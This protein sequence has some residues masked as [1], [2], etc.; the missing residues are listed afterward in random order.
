MKNIGLIGIIFFLSAFTLFSQ[1]KIK[2][3]VEIEPKKVS[4][5]LKSST[6]H[7]VRLELQW[8]RPDLVLGITIIELPNGTLIGGEEK[9]GGSNSLIVNSIT[10]PGLL[11]IVI[12]TEGSSYFQ[13]GDF[14]TCTF[15][16][17]FDEELKINSSRIIYW[18]AG[19]EIGYRLPLLGRPRMNITE[20]ALC[21]GD[22]SK[23]EFEG[24]INSTDVWRT[25][26]DLI[27]LYFL[28]GSEYV[29]FYDSNKSIGK[30]ISLLY[31]DLLNLLK[32]ASIKYD[33]ICNEGS[34]RIILTA[35]INDIAKYDS[36]NV[37]GKGKYHFESYNGDSPRLFQK[38][39]N[40]TFC[41]GVD[42]E[43]ACPAQDSITDETRFTASLIKGTEI[44][45][46]QDPYTEVEG[47]ELNNLKYIYPTIQVSFKIINDVPEDFDSLII[48][49]TSSDIDIEPYDLIIKKELPKLKVTIVP[50]ELAPG[51]TANVILQKRNADGSYGAFPDG[52]LFYPDLIEGLDYAKLLWEGAQETSFYEIPDGFK[53][54]A[55]D[56]ID[57]DSVKVV[58]RVGTYINDEMPAAA[59]RRSKNNLVIDNKTQTIN[60]DVLPVNEKDKIKKKNDDK[61][62]LLMIGGGGEGEY[63]EGYSNALI[64]EVECCTIDYDDGNPRK[65]PGLTEVTDAMFDITQINNNPKC[66]ETTGSGDNPKDRA[67][68]TYSNI[69]YQNPKYPLCAAYY[70]TNLNFEIIW[71]ICLDHLKD[72]FSDDLIFV[73]QNTNMPQN[74]DDADDMVEDFNRFSFNEAKLHEEVRGEI[75]Y[76]PLPSTTEHE[77]THTEQRKSLME[78]EYNQLLKKIYDN[79]IPP[80]DWCLTENIEK[81]LADRKNKFLNLINATKVQLEKDISDNKIE[82][83]REAYHAGMV[84]R[85]KLIA[86][87]Y[88]SLL[89]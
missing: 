58:L 75:K 70:L 22:T 45:I 72:K 28:E 59:K 21:F 38:G 34:K 66:D 4:K 42:I 17:Y 39:N 36:I 27:K 6:T 48:R 64:T 69:S 8:T 41:M 80:P 55:A 53:L 52:Q 50:S 31:Y 57:V 2:E 10:S 88:H 3:K 15:Q 76:Y 77:L 7:T 83:E 61:P 47:V 89:P 1:V 73:D 68:V 46:L 26:K 67:G 63:V 78:Q 14:Y 44:G 11:D 33:N 56:S 20:T 29:S 35:E 32:H 13:P 74:E 54:V 24:Y 37:N 82:N 60:K 71:G 30:S 43:G 18:G 81:V 86:D 25:D 16:I 87:I 65:F 49:F 19:A 23:I 40:L 84:A 62:S 79:R 9:A 12:G 51:D 85:Y 5:L